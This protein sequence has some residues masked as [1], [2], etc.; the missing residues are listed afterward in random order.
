MK[1]I[2]TILRGAYDRH[3]LLSYGLWVTAWGAGCFV[4]RGEDHHGWE[5]VGWTLFGISLVLQPW[6]TSRLRK[7]KCTKL[8]AEIIEKQRSKAMWS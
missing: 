6:V 8:H 1:A 5:W 2:W 3:W 7:A 4:Q